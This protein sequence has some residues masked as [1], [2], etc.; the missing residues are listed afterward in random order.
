MVNE[1]PE[2][3]FETVESGWGCKMLK[4]AIA[5]WV[6]GCLSV[7][8]MSTLPN[9]LPCIMHK[10]TPLLQGTCTTCASPKPPHQLQWIICLYL[11]R[12]LC[13]RFVNPESGFLTMIWTLCWMVILC[14]DPLLDLE[15]RYAVRPLKLLLGRPA[16]SWRERTWSNGW[17]EK[18]QWL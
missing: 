1:T 4:E 8:A 5:Q 14:V 7:L 18:L 13:L 6:F 15:R 9:T 16:K 17:P 12:K 2:P 3:V 11:M 10:S